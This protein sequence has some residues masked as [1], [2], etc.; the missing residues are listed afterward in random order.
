MNHDTVC[1]KKTHKKTL[2]TIRPLHMHYY[3]QTVHVCKWSFRD[4]CKT[5]WVYERL[6]KKI[7][8]PI[9]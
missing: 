3:E 5:S 1:K 8:T 4:V 9:I 2:K 7:Y 6:T